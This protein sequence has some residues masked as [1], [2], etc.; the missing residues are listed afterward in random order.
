MKDRALIQ[1][2][3]IA[4]ALKYSQNIGQGELTIWH[5]AKLGDRKIYRNHNGLSK[6]QNHC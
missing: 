3:Y 5:K 1:L 4:V 6:I 2:A